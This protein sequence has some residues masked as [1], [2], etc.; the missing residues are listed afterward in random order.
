MIYSDK[1]FIAEKIKKARKNAKLKQSELAERIGISA[2][3]LSKI[4][5][6]K[7]FP[8]LD[9]FLKMVE[10]LNLS[11]DDFGIKLPQETNKDKEQLLKIILSADNSEIK[12]YLDIILNF[13]RVVKT[14]P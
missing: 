14:K 6:A 10:V 13:R 9:N 2:K 1:G 12:A 11:L 5:T 4:E 3:H 8:A 7:N